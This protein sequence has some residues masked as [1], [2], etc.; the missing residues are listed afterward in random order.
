ML[1]QMISV[2]KRRGAYTGQKLR[3]SLICALLAFVTVVATPAELA[4]QDNTAGELPNVLPPYSTS[5]NGTDARLT[6]PH[7]RM[8]NLPGAFTLEAWLKP[9]TLA[10]R[11]VVVARLQDGAGSAGYGLRLEADR[12]TLSLC[13]DQ[14]RCVEVAS[15]TPLMP[16][17]WQHV[18]AVY[19]G[20]ELRI[21]ING[22]IAG[23]RSTRALAAPSFK[24]PLTIGGHANGAAMYHGLLDEIRL[25]T[26]AA[27]ASN[28][29]PAHQPAVAAN[30]VALW[31]FDGGVSTDVTSNGNHASMS[32]AAGY[33]PDVPALQSATFRITPTP[34]VGPSNDLT[35]VKTVSP[36]EVWAVGSHGPAD[37][38]CFPK[39]PVSLR[40]DG[41][42]W[43]NVP[44]PVP[45]GT[46]SSVLVAVDATSPTNV[47]AVGTI[48]PA[49]QF[50]DGVWLLRWDGAQWNTVAIVFDPVY[51][52]HGIGVVKSLTVI[53]ETDVWIV[54]ARIG[55][56]SW[57]LHWDGISLQTVPS[58]NLDNGNSLADVDALNSN[59]VW[60]VGSFMVI[61]YNGTEWLPVPN[62]PRHVHFSS[63]EVISP[64]DVWATGTSTTCGPFSGCSSSDGLFHFD[65]SQWTAVAVP[66]FNAHMFLK[67]LSATASDNVW[68]VGNDAV[69]R[70]YVAHFNGATWQ[71][72]AS[73][74][75]PPASSDLDRLVSVS[76]L[77][78]VDVWSVG[79]AIDIFYD[80]H[81]R[82]VRSTLAL[83][84][85]LGP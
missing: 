11:Q 23:R 31:R 29:T 81:H 34:N 83:R 42:Q 38:C 25:S 24:A 36:T 49:G 61:R 69:N 48:R 18:A 28:F 10:G 51:P 56:Y 40:W 2:A 67:D 9:A 8:L 3:V 14:A 1:E 12:A 65:G 76:A 7:S 43:N 60:A 50:H 6:V 37:R 35:G 5:L 45:P 85:T 68:L 20:S 53:S 19:D 82:E 55:G 39:T 74:N 26:G 27:Y 62:A 13:A 32:G 79:F 70:T 15:E 75:T 78:S 30:T 59:D 63:V 47:W 77:N 21:Y 71:R 80:P 64:N 57:T 41:S 84:R 52:T 58:P 54:G 22:H 17:A 44:L 16:N 4:A 72:V 73:E 46:G 33:S 66:D